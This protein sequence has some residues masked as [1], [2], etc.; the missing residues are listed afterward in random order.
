[1]LP[2]TPISEEL[3]KAGWLEE[4]YKILASALR[5]ANDEWKG[6]LL[7]AMALVDKEK[8]WK[9]AQ[10][11]KTYDNGNSQAN[12]LYWIATRP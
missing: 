10:T 7:M 2:F 9:R 12:L 8:A 5:T 3:L 11:L 4:E 1:M 6:Y